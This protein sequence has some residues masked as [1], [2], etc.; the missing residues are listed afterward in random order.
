MHYEGIYTPRSGPTLMF[1][2]SLGGANWV[3]SLS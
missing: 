1:P 3:G 2:G